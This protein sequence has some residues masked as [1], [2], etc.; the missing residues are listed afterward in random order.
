MIGINNLIIWNIINA[1]FFLSNIGSVIGHSKDAASTVR[2]K[3]KKMDLYCDMPCRS[4]GPHN[5]VSAS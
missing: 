2:K 3:Q 5:Q 4:D 1:D